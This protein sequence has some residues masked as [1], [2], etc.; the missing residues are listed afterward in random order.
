MRCSNVTTSALA[1][2]IGGLLT[3]GVLSEPAFAGIQNENLRQGLPGRRI[4]GGSRSPR[5]AC[6]NTIP[7]Q[8][9][10]ALMPEGNI[11]LTLSAHPTFWF[12]LPAISAGKSLEFGLFNQAGEIVYQKTLEASEEAGITHLSL[13]EN[14]APLEVDQDYRWYLSVVCNPNSRSEDLFVTGWVKRVQPDRN[15]SQQLAT[16]T[17]QE[18]LALYEES[19][20]WYDILTTLAELRRKS[21]TDTELAQRWSTLLESVNL[22]QVI[23]P[24]TNKPISNETL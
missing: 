2:A 3:L 15:I 7:N 24:P 1:L 12:S 22:T 10:I 14:T 18:R 8:P 17:D 13:P 5:P 9:V 20:L 21:P 16:A 6:L 11:G 23:A 19:A 4:S